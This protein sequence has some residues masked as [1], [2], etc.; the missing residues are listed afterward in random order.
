MCV[1]R[2][3][4]FKVVT[5]WSCNL[6][7]LSLAE[8][9]FAEVVPKGVALIHLGTNSKFMCTIGLQQGLDYFQI[10]T[11]NIMIHIAEIQ[12][13]AWKTHQ[14]VLDVIEDTTLSDT[15][16]YEQGLFWLPQ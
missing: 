11:V 14:E 10:K 7:R 16:S 5:L 6:M 1:P 2:D 3:T 12:K 15:A 4:N 9:A 8:V 13:E